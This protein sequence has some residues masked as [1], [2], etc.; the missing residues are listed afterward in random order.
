M[1]Y[2]QSSRYTAYH[3][4]EKL[5]TAMDV[6]IIAP[7]KIQPMKDMLTLHNALGIVTVSCLCGTFS[8]VLGEVKTD[9]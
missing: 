7:D 3:Q 1:G 5:V 2:Y 4:N 6:G 8:L 9:R